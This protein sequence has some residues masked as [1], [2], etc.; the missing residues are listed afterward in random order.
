MGFREEEGGEV[1]SGEGGGE[2]WR[3]TD[4]PVRCCEGFASRCSDLG[5]LI[6]Q[7][8][9]AVLPQILDSSSAAEGRSSNP[10][11]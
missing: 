11:W 7:L 3:L 9:L 6:P 1:K 2:R 5:F 10:G 4:G 8:L